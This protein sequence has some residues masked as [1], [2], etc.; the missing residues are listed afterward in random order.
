MIKK[1]TVM[2]STMNRYN[3]VLGLLVLIAFEVSAQTP[4]EEYSCFTAVLHDEAA[5]FTQNLTD[6]L[7]S[8]EQH[9]L[10]SGKC[11]RLYMVVL[12]DE[13]RD[14][15]LAIHTLIYDTDEL[16][17]EHM[18]LIDQSKDDMTERSLIWYV[19]TLMVAPDRYVMTELTPPGENTEK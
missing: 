15:I 3:L 4:N 10:V 1:D 5:E 8:S 11:T 17:H 16:A 6:K 9:R 7:D 19:N 14:N 13:E 2:V 12:Y 18:M